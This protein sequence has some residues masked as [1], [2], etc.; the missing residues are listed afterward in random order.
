MMEE[1]VGELTNAERKVN[2]LQDLNKQDFGRL[3]YS[4]KAQLNYNAKDAGFFES[5]G[6]QNFYRF[7]REMEDIKNSDLFGYNA[8]AAG[9]FKTK[10]LMFVE[11]KFEAEIDVSAKIKSEAEITAKMIVE[12]AREDFGLQL[13]DLDKQDFCRLEYSAEA[14]LAAK[15]IKEKVGELTIT[16]TPTTRCRRR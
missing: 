15:T 10:V 2:K 1:K 12:K 8:K 11:N 3:Y 4:A 16:E 13:Q 9:F 5:E 7:F 14:K 6:E